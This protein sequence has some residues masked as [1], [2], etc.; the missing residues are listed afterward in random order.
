MPPLEDHDLR[1]VTGSEY[2]DDGFLGVQVDAPGAGNAGPPIQLHHTYGFSSRPLDPDPDGRGADVHVAWEGSE[3][4]AW[5]A[6]DGRV[7]RLLPIKKQGETLQNGPKGNF[8][9]CHDDG[10][11]SLFTSDDGTVDGRSV[12]VEVAP[13]GI[14]FVTPW[15]KLVLDATGF[16]VLTESGAR[17]DLG[18]I[19]GLPAPLSALTSYAVMRANT[20]TCEGSLVQLG[21]KTPL[22]YQPVAFCNYEAVPPPGPALP[23]LTLTSASV[24]VAM[25]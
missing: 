7:T 9:R 10:R 17:I 21:P 16:H 1:T 23:G 20:V 25:L 12:Y 5:M 14:R 3:R 6:S 13:D 8:V 11:I 18:A 2:D 24:R 15:G 4:H 19:G 22:G